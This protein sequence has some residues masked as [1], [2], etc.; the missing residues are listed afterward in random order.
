MADAPQDQN[1]SRIPPPPDEVAV[2][3]MKG[4]IDSLASSGGTI[5]P[6]FIT[7][8]GGGAVAQSKKSDAMMTVLIFIVATVVAALALYYFLFAK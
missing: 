6:Q 8:T 2:R 1:L 7:M 4:D 5:G 3:T